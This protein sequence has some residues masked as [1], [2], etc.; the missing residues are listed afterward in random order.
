M[1]DKGV[2]PGVRRLQLSKVITKS[3]GSQYV[4][5]W[6]KTECDCRYAEYRIDV[7]QSGQSESSNC[8]PEWKAELDQSRYYDEWG[9]PNIVFAESPHSH[10]KASFDN[11]AYEGAKTDLKD[12]RPYRFFKQDQHISPIADGIYIEEMAG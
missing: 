4:R 2:G 3:E 12:K 5:E 7:G 8:E 6:T 10:R 1:I 11:G 9:Y